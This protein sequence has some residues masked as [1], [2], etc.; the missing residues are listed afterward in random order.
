MKTAVYPGSFDPITNGHLDIISRAAKLFDRV[1]VGVAARAEKHPL[2]TLD[3]RVALVK[4][5]TTQWPGLEVTGFSD[6]LVDFA[7]RMKAQTVIRGMRAV[8]D[9]DYEFQMVLT[10]RKI[11]PDVETVF[12]LASEKHFY[13]S[14]RM[15]KEIAGL[16]GPVSCFI[17]VEA[18]AA[19]KAKFPG[20]H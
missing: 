13:L 19:L 16:G 17:P 8:M 2:F 10:N 20:C 4:K 7:R 15:V 14:S 3:E 6:L 5:V 18:L 12:F 11:A 1:I 9:F